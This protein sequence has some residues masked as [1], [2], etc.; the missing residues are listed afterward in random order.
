MDQGVSPLVNMLLAPL[1]PV[2]DLLDLTIEAA[3]AVGVLSVG[4]VTVFLDRS[5]SD[6][7]ATGR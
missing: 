6:P 3:T 5:L 1:R 7:R 2:A 4:L